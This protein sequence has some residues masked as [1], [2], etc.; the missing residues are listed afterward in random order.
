MPIMVQLPYILKNNTRKVAYQTP[1]K[2]L[3]TSSVPVSKRKRKKFKMTNEPETDHISSTGNNSHPGT[4][5]MINCALNAPLMLMAIIGNML[6]LSA[7]LKTP[8]LRSPSTVFLSSLAISDLLVGLVVQP[9]YIAN[10]LTNDSLYTLRNTTA[11]SACAVSLFT[12][13]AVSVDRVLAI[14]YHLRYTDL[15]T[16]NRAVVTSIILWFLSFLLSFLTFWQVNAYYFAAAASIVVCVFLSAFCYIRIYAVARH[17][18]LQIHVQQQAVESSRA[19][20]N[21]QSLQ[22]SAKSAKNT[23]IYYVVMLLCY[24]PLFMA[25]IMLGISHIQQSSAWI[26]AETVTFMNSSI[27]PFLYCWRLPD[28]RAAVVKTTK[29]TLCMQT[30]EN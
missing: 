27:N 30:E 14:H 11:F 12:I 13:T 1:V 9:I 5:V 24:I 2:T 25:M 28:L 17:H 15:M 23:F 26:L 8:S 20:N 18:L 6:V 29:Q 10:E 7:I 3:K 4:I 19:E 16:P 21:N 22:L